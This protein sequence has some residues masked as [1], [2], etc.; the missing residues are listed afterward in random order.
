MTAALIRR[1]HAEIWQRLPKTW[2]RAGLEQLA[3]FLAPRP[4]ARPSAGRHVVV[5]GV[6]GASSGLGQSA[7]L[8]ERAFLT[9][10]ENVCRADVSDIFLAE[11]ATAQ[12]EEGLS[13]P[14]HGPGVIVAHI[15]APLLPL[16]LLRLGR[17]R[18]EGCVV[19]G[20]WAW[21]L[22]QIP[23]SW[24]RGLDFVHEIWVPSRFVRDAVAPVAGEIPVRIVPHPVAVGPTADALS[25]EEPG[26]DPRPF[27]VL[28]MFDMA[29]GFTR[30]NPLAAVEAFRQAFSNDLGARLI[31]K[32][33]NPEAYPEGHKLLLEATGANA[34]IRIDTTV[35]SRQQVS[36]L[37]A[38]SDVLLS[39][40]R[41]E[42]FGL[43][44]AEAM[45]AGLPVV[46]T[47]W[48]GCTD[49]VDSQC[50]MPVPFKLTSACDPQGEYAY[51]GMLWAEPDICEA[52][53]ALRLLHDQPDER[54]RLGRNGRLRAMER[55]SPEG[56]AHA[57]D[58]CRSRFP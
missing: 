49:F 31:V 28:V 21:E 20:Y 43:G 44:I 53:H 35:M 22:P 55:F 41:S 57:L 52:A 2:R 4:T 29:S 11:P 46:C 45:L 9:L 3:G 17:R 42:G 10:G 56:Y 8:C 18:I 34:N 23:S 36:S 39:L 24:R 50:G 16:A 15:N 27:T 58:A 33:Q 12:S 14:D 1:L 47:D 54:L 37:I 7:R 30:K 40:H 25:V 26:G 32:C 6:L 48:S 13:E 19:V 5:A 38:R 51:G